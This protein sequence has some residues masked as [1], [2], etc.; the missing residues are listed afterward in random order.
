MINGYVS[1]AVTLS[2]LAIRLALATQAGAAIS[3]LAST[4]IERHGVPLHQAPSISIMRFINNGP[5]LSAFDLWSGGHWYRNSLIYTL[6]ILLACTTSISQ[7]TSTLLLWDIE[8]GNVLGFPAEKDLDAGFSMNDYMEHFR[9]L[10]TQAPNYWASTPSTYNTFAEWS[11]GADALP[12][13]AVDTGPTIRALLP[14]TSNNDLLELEEYNGTASLFDARVSCVRPTI[15]DAAF[16]FDLQVL[17]N[18]TGTLFPVSVPEEIERNSILSTT[19]IFPEGFP[20]TC[21]MDNMQVGKS[22]VVCALPRTAGGLINSLDPMNNKSL[23]HSLDPPDPGVGLWH[24]SSSNGSGF[25]WP[26]LMGHTVLFWTRTPGEN[27]AS[28]N[29]S[30]GFDIAENGPWLEY[31][32]R[33]TGDTWSVSACFDAL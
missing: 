23:I 4:L 7:F 32:L 11:I 28:S 18:F 29:R 16:N 30:G 6:L 9:T 27:Q 12:D 5:V 26:V 24:A 19:G 25:Q 22:F 31:T 21:R 8:S 3:M 13:H 14:I 10:L 17:E 33:D 20:F 1:Q 2:T 15:E